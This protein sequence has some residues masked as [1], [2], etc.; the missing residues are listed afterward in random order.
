MNNLAP[1]EEGSRIRLLS[2]P[3]D[4]HPI[5][6]GSEGVVDRVVKLW[7]NEW[8]IGVVWDSG[9][10]LSLI[11]PIDRFSVIAVPKSSN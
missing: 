4:P 5:P 2:M 11:Y 3:N 9:R 8:Q 6:A 1:V 10:T 7:G